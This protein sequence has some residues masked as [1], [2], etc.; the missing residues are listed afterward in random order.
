M[1]LFFVVGSF[2]MGGTERTASRIGLELLRR[3]H[4]VRFVLL[5][6]VFDYNDPGL[7]ENSIILGDAKYK[8]K[9]VRMF[10][11]FF[12][13]VSVLRKEKPDYLI[14]FSIGINLLILFTFYRRMIF[15]IEANIFIYKKKLYRRYFQKIAPL[16]PQVKKVVVPSQGLYEKCCEYFYKPYKLVQVS[17]P[18][19]VGDIMK[20]SEEPLAEFSAL[21]NRKFIVTAGRLH[22][23]K[24]FAQLIEVFSRSPL[25]GEYALVIL[26]EGP[27]KAELQDI[28]EKM[29][30]G[31]DVFVLGYQ[32][33]PYRF[34]S[35]ARFF[36]LNSRHESFGN[37]LIEAMACGTPIV[38]NDCDFGPRHIIRQNH[39]GVL[40]RCEVEAEFIETLR[41]VAFD[42]DFYARL[43]EGV[44]TERKQY[45]IRSIVDYWENSVLVR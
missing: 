40:Y 14:S 39:N 6:G 23:S 29:G 41:H 13:L 19:I 15:R 45:D 3:G 28:A 34:F 4:N 17:N 26:G 30:V 12:K 16:L 44:E 42:E 21:A 11:S 24:G 5:N 32:S 38:S 36:I 9:F 18:I 20:L 37:V 8:N 43:R 35:R 1:K 25:S 27:Q 22:E 10:F 7:R 2:K 31:R 33:N